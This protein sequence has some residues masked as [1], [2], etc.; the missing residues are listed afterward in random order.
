MAKITN[1]VAQI[2][3]PPAAARSPDSDVSPGTQVPSKSADYFSAN[4]GANGHLKPNG[5]S[6]QLSAASA[7][8]S[9][10]T[11]TSISEEDFQVDSSRQSSNDSGCPSDG[12]HRN[13]S[14]ASVSFRPPHNPSLPQGHPRKTDKRRLRASSPSPVR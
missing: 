7:A 12:H 3:S 10:T 11:L 4:S 14:S 2:T 1:H 13:S 6:P 8:P 9:M 5:V